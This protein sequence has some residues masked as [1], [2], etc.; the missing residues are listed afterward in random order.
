MQSLSTYF[1]AERW[2]KLIARAQRTG[3]SADDITAL[4]GEMVATRQ[5]HHPKNAQAALI[6]AANGFVC[7][8][9]MSPTEAD[10]KAFDSALAA[11]AV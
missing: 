6:G 5:V 9:G 4:A 1:G 3:M 10:V 2:A 7:E 8:I 11:T